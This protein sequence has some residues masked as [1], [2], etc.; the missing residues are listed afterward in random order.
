V[1]TLTM[2]LSPYRNPPYRSPTPKDSNSPP[3]VDPSPK[4][5]RVESEARASTPLRLDTAADASSGAD[6]P[7]TRVAERLKDLDL[8]QQ[9]QQTP[10]AQ[11]GDA[12]VG[13][14]RKRLKRGQHLAQR[15]ERSDGYEGTSDDALPPSSL[16]EEEPSS[17]PSATF[18]RSVSPLEIGETP[19]CRSTRFQDSPPVRSPDNVRVAKFT[20]TE[21]EE[22]TAT[23]E[24]P[25]EGKKK[26]RLSSPPPPAPDS[27]GTQSS[28]VRRPTSPQVV[29]DDDSQISID[30]ASLKWQDPELTGHDIDATTPDDD[31]EGINGIGFKPTAAIAYARSQKRKKQVSEWRAREAREERQRRFER[32]RG[33]ASSGGGTGSGA[34]EAQA[35]IGLRRM[36]RFE[37][38][39]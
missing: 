10:P 3:P 19:D 7:R 13:A 1:I 33:T 36:V 4:R 9:H 39:D 2:I 28:P 23:S 14:P 15:Y 8:H 20:V 27:T 37:G 6:S 16:P 11:S 18:S 32:R 21:N 12:I 5:K 30:Q 22:A 31:G 38:V 25:G 17:Q 26:K 34:V 24:S 35:E 29:I